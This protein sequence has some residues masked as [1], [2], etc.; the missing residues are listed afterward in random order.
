MEKKEAENNRTKSA[1]NPVFMQG[2]EHGRSEARFT[3]QEKYVN[4]YTKAYPILMVYAN[5]YATLL[6]KYDLI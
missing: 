6:K 2:Y 4:F 5:F 3:I 1:T